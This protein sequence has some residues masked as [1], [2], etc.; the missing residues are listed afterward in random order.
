VTPR[1]SW[2]TPWW[3]WNH[4]HP[5]RASL[6]AQRKRPR[7]ERARSPQSTSARAALRSPPS[8]CSPPA[9]FWTDPEGS[10]PSCSARRRLTVEWHHGA[11]AITWGPTGAA[12][13]RRC[14]T[15][16]AASWTS[17]ARLA[18]RR[19]GCRWSI[20]RAANRG[21]PSSDRWRTRVSDVPRGH[22]RDRCGAGVPGLSR[23]GR[24]P[25]RYH[26]V[27]PTRVQARMAWGGGRT[28]GRGGAVCRG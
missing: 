27:T 4:A 18:E 8:S 5:D 6:A 23:P 17:W 22:D 19:Q 20:H 21:L 28:R 7:R 9:T 3:S 16:T 13:A 14:A 24:R 12:P 11:I 2:S 25:A 1:W 26:Q 10:D 15:P